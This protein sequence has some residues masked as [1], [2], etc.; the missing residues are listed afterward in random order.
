MIEC[1][2]PSCKVVG[3]PEFVPG[4]E[5]PK[6][7]GQ[8]IMGPYGW[9]QGDGWLVGSGPAYTYMACS[10][11]CVGPAIV[12]LVEEARRRENDGYE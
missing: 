8:R 2:N 4:R 12:A 5:G 1:D 11:E 6:K 9:H 10:A 3:Q 7:R